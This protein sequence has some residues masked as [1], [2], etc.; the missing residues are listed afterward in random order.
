MKKCNCASFEDLEM[1]RKVIS[2]RIKESKRLKKKLTLLATTEDGEHV[3]MK[4]DSCNQHWQGSRAWNWGNDLYLFR[5]PKLEPIEWQ[6]EVY[7]QPK[8]S[9]L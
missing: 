6:Q 9:H 7:V 3:L 5:V 8:P 2:K 4:C 1:L